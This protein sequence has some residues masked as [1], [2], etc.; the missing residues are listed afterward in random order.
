MP[1]LNTVR[2]VN[3]VTRLCGD[4]GMGLSEAGV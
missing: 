3:I 2:L 4:K 1:G